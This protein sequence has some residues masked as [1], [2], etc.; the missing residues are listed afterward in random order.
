MFCDEKKTNYD[1]NVYPYATLL[2]PLLIYG[3]LCFLTRP[4]YF[5]VHFSNHLQFKPFPLTIVF[6]G[7]YIY[8]FNDAACIFIFQ[9]FSTHR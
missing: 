4:L 5:S 3:Q 8:I 1:C 7:L 6:L 2:S 9:A